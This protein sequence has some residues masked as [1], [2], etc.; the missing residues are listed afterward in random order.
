MF[1]I[2][3]RIESSCR[4]VLKWFINPCIIV[5]YLAFKLLTYVRVIH[6]RFRYLFLRIRCISDLLQV[7]GLVVSDLLPN[8]RRL[9]HPARPQKVSQFSAESL[10]Q[11]QYKSVIDQLLYNYYKIIAADSSA[12]AG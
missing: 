9:A 7:L 10:F 1:S 8:S 6:G 4:L 12:A 5:L 2:L 3:S 11:S